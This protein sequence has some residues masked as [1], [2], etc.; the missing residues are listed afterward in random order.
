MQTAFMSWVSALISARV[1]MLTIPM[2]FCTE[3][4]T[5]V[6]RRSSSC[7]RSAELST[8]KRLLLADHFCKVL[9]VS[10]MVPS[11]SLSAARV[12]P[13]APIPLK[14]STR[15]GTNCSIS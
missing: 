15:A 7:V 2:A 6:C 11:K 4:I 12:M 5:L 10:I 14:R 9:V 3:S 8:R 13:L 1:D